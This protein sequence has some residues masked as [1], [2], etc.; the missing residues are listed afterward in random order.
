[1]T[2]HKLTAG[3]GYDYLTRQVAVLDSTEKGSLGLAAYY[4]ERGESPGVWVGAGMGGIEA[5]SAGDLVTAEQMQALFGHGQH[6][7]ATQRQAELQAA[8]HSTG[9]EPVSEAALAAVA[10]LGAPFKVYAPDVSPFRREVA[11]R[12]AEVNQAAGLP[13]DWPVAAAERARVRT[14]VGVEFFRAEHGRDP[15]D[16][17]ELAGGI[18]KHSRPRTQ[19]V[20]GYDLTFSPVKSV[21]VLWAL[22]DPQVAA[23]VEQAEAPQV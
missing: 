7:L 3:S 2:I 22:A 10:G 13:S 23:T 18:A 4:A 19:A 15:G 9:G 8:A 17:R 16:A 5:L 21:S 6:P 14:E 11:R 20:A 1:M 12:I